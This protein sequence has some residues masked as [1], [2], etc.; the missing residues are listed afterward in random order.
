MRQLKSSKKNNL[1]SKK[2]QGYCEVIN[3]LYA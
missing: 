2:K 1:K 3:F